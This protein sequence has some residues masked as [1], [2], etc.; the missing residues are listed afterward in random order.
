MA[1]FNNRKSTKGLKKTSEKGVYYDVASRTT[2]K[3]DNKGNLKMQV[4]E[5]ERK[6]HKATL[7]R[8]R[9]YEKKYNILLKREKDIEKRNW[10]EYVD[11]V[12][13]W[14]KGE[15]NRANT[16]G[17]KLETLTT[18][19]NVTNRYY[20][21]ENIKLSSDITEKRKVMVMR[22][23]GKHGVY[24]GK[25]Y[26]SYIQTLA[27]RLKVT[28]E[29]I[30]KHLFPNGLEESSKYDDIVNTLNVG[31]NTI[32]DLIDEQVKKGLISENDAFFTRELLETGEDL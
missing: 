24:N 28:P 2:F 16:V 1:N 15:I 11:S 14:N 26:D 20:S 30:E 19:R 17:K 22:M 10:K 5:F 21:S 23:S 29:I 32:D 3:R 6:A 7:E 25:A 13:K 18:R 31:M 9:Y 4:D 8:L 27:D 12:K